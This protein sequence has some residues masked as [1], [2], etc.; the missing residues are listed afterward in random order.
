MSTVDTG[1]K[2]KLRILIAL[3][4]A[5]DLKPGSA[6]KP[7][8]V[9]P[10]LVIKTKIIKGEGQGRLGIGSYSGNENCLR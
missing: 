2:L 8:L 6:T 9:K 5:I 7:L 10:L 1:G 4:G 3:K